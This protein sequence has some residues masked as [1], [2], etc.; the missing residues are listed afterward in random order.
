MIGNSGKSHAADNRNNKMIVDSSKGQSENSTMNHNNKKS[1]CTS[2]LARMNVLARMSVRARVAK[3]D[4][5]K[6]GG[7][8]FG[9][10]SHQCP[11]VARRVGESKS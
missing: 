2:E 6:K 10:V 3:S 4:H 7:R 9:A 11:R 5:R 1:G 8:R